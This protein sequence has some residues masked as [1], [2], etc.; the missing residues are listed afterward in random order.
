ME[1]DAG[2]GS[3]PPTLGRVCGQW[4]RCPD[5]RGGRFC[6]IGIETIDDRPGIVE[7]SES[8]DYE[9]DEGDFDPKG[10]RPEV[11]V[12]FGDSFGQK[13]VFANN[14]LRPEVD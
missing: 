8:S 7:P 11:A 1:K 12:R 9:L 5:K 6:E 3:E 10:A 14:S 13:W 4:Q 2:A